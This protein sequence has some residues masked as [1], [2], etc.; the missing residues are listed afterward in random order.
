VSHAPQGSS[1]SPLE[2]ASGLVF[3]VERDP[4]SALREAATSPRAALEAA[5]LEALRQPPCVVTFSGGLDSSVVLAVASSVARREGLELPLAGTLRFPGRPEA[6]ESSW[7]E[8]V[9]AQVPVADWRRIEIGG[10]LS[11]VGPV[12]TDTLREHGLLWPFNAY[13]HVPLFEL[14]RGGSVLTG[15]GGDELFLPS[16]WDRLDARRLALAAAPRAVR[17]RVLARRGRGPRLD[18]LEQAAQT[19]LTRAW[20]ASEAA[21]P[22]GRRA[23]SLWRLG[24]RPIRAADRSL[25]A[26]AERRD[27]ALVHPFTAPPVVTAFADDGR[28]TA[29]RGERLRAVAGNLLPAELFDRRTKAGFNTALWGDDARALAAEWSGEGVDP[30][31]VNPDAVRAQWAAE[32]PDA[33]T[34]TML[35]SAWLSR[36]VGSRGVSRVGAEPSP[37][38]TRGRRADG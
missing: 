20:A 8:R 21:A 2:V 4:P 37:S 6:D 11:V 16:R 3:G 24:L 38:A 22:V 5:V 9:V 17:R 33:R 36:A 23:R 12:A 18:W 25:A 27:V 7:Q 28:G 26:L 34:F 32:V 14:A 13:V 35:Q 29:R 30:S 31:L 1:L 10:E 15:F 19:A